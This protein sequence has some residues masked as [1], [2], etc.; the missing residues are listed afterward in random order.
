MEKR[1]LGNTDIAVTPFGMGVLTIG[2]T[3]LACSLDEGARL[4]RYAIEQGI[5]FLDTAEF[6][7]TYHYIRRALSRSDLPRPVIASKSLA[8]DYD[9]MSRAIENCR[10]ELD[11]DQIDI[12]LLHEVV[13]SPD[14]E[15]RIGAWACLIDAKAKGLVKAI[16][17]STHHACAAAEAV[18]TPG[19]DILFPLINFQGLGVRKG[20]S[21]GTRE[22][23]EKAINAAAEAGIGVFTMKAFGGGNLVKDY[24]KALD[25]VTGLPG[26]QSVMIGFG[27]RKDVDDAVAYLEGRMPKDYTPDVSKKRMFVDRGDCI[28][29]GSC[30]RY[31]TSMAITFGE[32]GIAEVDTSK[33]ILCGYCVPVC[34]TRALL[35]L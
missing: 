25:Y 14:F 27:C 9:S 18:N 5:D 20:D 11:I 23:M 8:E 24:V 3:Q 1:V 31:C 19:M 7:Q 21:E 28:G 26:V 4:V 30:V 35:F 34:P 13:Q 12:F 22:E 16:G 2:P 17:I 33:C 15:N 29:C 6:Y 32:D 10:I